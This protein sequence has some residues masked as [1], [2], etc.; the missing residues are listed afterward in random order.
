MSQKLIQMLVL[1]STFFGVA[2]LSQTQ[3]QTQ[4]TCGNAITTAE[5]M[6]CLGLLHD[7][8]DAH[9][10]TAYKTHRANLDG[11]GQKVLRDAQIAW[12]DFRDKECTRL[13]DVVRGGSLAQVIR[14]GCLINLTDMRTNDLLESAIEAVEAPEPTPTFWQSLPPLLGKFDCEN[15]LPARLGLVISQDPETL[16]SYLSARLAIGDHNIDIS[17]D[18][19]GDSLCGPDVSLHITNPTASCPGLRIDD[20]LCDGFFFSWNKNLKT[21]QYERN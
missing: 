11:A 12:I 5:Q 16:A 18:H 17:I 20:G 13:A 21:Y 7:T 15:L 14:I 4:Q 6:I 1:F 9:L 10:N 19:D 8:A 3:A 2:M